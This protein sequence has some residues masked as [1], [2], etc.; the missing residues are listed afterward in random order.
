MIIIKSNASFLYNTND[1]SKTVFDCFDSYTIEDRNPKENVSFQTNYLIPYCRRPL[2]TDPINKIQGYIE[3][4]YTFKNLSLQ[5]ITS[6]NL[7]QWSILIDIIEL[8][9]IYLIKKD[10]KFDE[11]VFNNCSSLW[12]GSNCQ[13]T[14]NL[15][16]PIESY[17][18]FVNYSFNAREQ[19]ERKILIHTCYPH[20]SGCYRGPEPMCLD[21]REICD[22][23]IDCIGDNFGIDEEYCNEL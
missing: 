9:S 20:L 22:G 10:T 4:T 2:S 3:N 19:Y 18:D 17:G 8:Y 6:E 12:F 15:S 16:M 1:N 21:W 5:G 13:Y 7:L 23:K 14:F 11:F